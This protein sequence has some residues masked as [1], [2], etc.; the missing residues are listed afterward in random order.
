MGLIQKTGYNS[1][2]KASVD[3]V[4]R[5]TQA[6]RNEAIREVRKTTPELTYVTR[7]EEHAVVFQINQDRSPVP[8]L[9]TLLSYV[10]QR[11]RTRAYPILYI[12]ETETTQSDLFQHL[13]EAIRKIAPAGMKIEML[14]I[15]SP[16]PEMQDSCILNFRTKEEFQTWQVGQEGR[17]IPEPPPE[18]PPPP[19]EQ[20]ILSP[21]P[22]SQPLPPATPDLNSV[23]TLTNGTQAILQDD[24][25]L[26]LHAETDLTKDSQPHRKGM[27]RLHY[28]P[29]PA[30]PIPAPP[31]LHD[32]G[33][34]L[35]HLTDKHILEANQQKLASHPDLRTLLEDQLEEEEEVVNY[36]IDSV[37][38]YLYRLIQLVR[39]VGTFPKDEEGHL[40]L[41]D[42][43]QEYRAHLPDIL[44]T[45]YY[46][47][48]RAYPVGNLTSFAALTASLRETVK[49][50][51]GVPRT[52]LEKREI[53]Q[54]AGEI[55]RFLT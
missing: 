21:V 50:G 42:R 54:Q 41:P 6:Q 17:Y 20:T 13:H 24:R 23:T 16:S 10:T 18:L 11:K 44:Q 55:N 19:P 3:R 35:A 34:A 46:T 37:N 32:V 49:D 4:H 51:E 38:Q 47:E 26:N 2:S 29:A 52:H 43:V 22:D 40:I 8:P 30:Q 9:R 45:T 5:M 33:S 27:N 25:L 53:V 12:L 1:Y 28:L 31:R 36:F 39:K 15:P 14:T 48:A 7:L